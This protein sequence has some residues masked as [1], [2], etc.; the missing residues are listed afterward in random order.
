M[1]WGLPVVVVCALAACA[2][3][4]SSP[5]DIPCPD[6]F[7]DCDRDRSNGCEIDVS[8]VCSDTV[9]ADMV[10]F[11]CVERDCVYEACLDDRYECDGDLAN[12]C[13]RDATAECDEVMNATDLAFDCNGCRYTCL[14]GF[15]DCDGDTQYGCELDVGALCAGLVHTSGVDYDCD[16]MTCT[17]ESCEPG[18]FDCNEGS[19]G[20]EHEGTACPV[21]LAPNGG[22]AI[23]VDDSGVYWTDD[24]DLYDANATGVVRRVALDGGAVSV[25][26]TGHG[27]G[28]LAIDATH[29]Y[30]TRSTLDNGGVRR[31]AKT[32]GVVETVVAQST[33][34]YWIALDATDAY[35]TSW[36]SVARVAKAGGAAVGLGTGRYGVAVDATNLYVADAAVYQQPLAGGAPV[37]L[38][39]AGPTGGAIGA[40]V[41][42]ETQVYWMTNTDGVYRVSIGGGVPILIGPGGSRWALA[43]DDTSVYWSDGGNIWAAPKLGGAAVLVAGGAPAS[44]IA[45][46][47]DDVY[48]AN[49][50]GIWTAPKP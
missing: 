16:A 5:A 38:D 46:W 37:Q 44:A 18:F 13:E 45:T 3:D 50:A 23:A 19:D 24:G 6:G 32:G 7:I 42:D 28:G 4:D 33:G 2:G 43:V 35:F 25:L 34:S 30:F 40:I 17:Y 48:W 1:R 29:V 8:V 9:G 47:G 39:A 14:P 22:S 11:A 49:G 41:V 21:S 31:V 36:G 26:A 20:C 12:G 27:A 10:T 15:R